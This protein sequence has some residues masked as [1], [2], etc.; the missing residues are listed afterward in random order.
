MLPEKRDDR[1]EVQNYVRAMNEA[2]R[3]LVNLPLS[4]RLIRLTHSKLM[5]NVRGKHKAP[6]EFRTSQNWIGGSSIAD[7]AYIPP[8][9]DDIPALLHDFEDF[10]A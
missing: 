4:L 3:Q 6:G 9:I 2:I 5:D 1:R 10:F 8:H 7:A